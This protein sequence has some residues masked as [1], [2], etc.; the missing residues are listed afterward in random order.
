[1]RA[2]VMH[3]F[4]LLIAL[5]FGIPVYA[6]T[7]DVTA[8]YNPATYEVGGAKFINTTPCT[9][10]PTAAGFWCS[11]TATVDMPQAVRFGMAISRTVKKSGDNR[12]GLHYIGFPGERNVTLL[13]EGGG[14]SYNIK[15]IITAVGSEISVGN[16]TISTLPENGDCFSSS[17]WS[18]NVALFL[19]RDVKMPNQVVG[20]RCYGNSDTYIGKNV[21]IYSAYLGYKLKAP[22]PL[23]M[24]NGTYTGKL[25]LSI[26][27]KKDLDFG[28]GT[29]TDTELR[30]SFK[31]KVRHQIKVEFTPGSDKV[32]LQPPGGWH[33]WIYRGKSYL[34]PYLIAELPYR[35]WSSS[36]YNVWLNC[37]YS[38]GDS[39]MLNN[40]RLKMQVLLDVIYVNKAKKEI[41]LKHGI[42]QSFTTIIDGPYMNEARS[43]IFKI[44]KPVLALM[45]EYPGSTYKGNVTIIYD[46]A[47]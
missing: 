43:I 42:T 33:D 14:A 38:N 27:N 36:D 31:I 41:A 20:G 16:P 45:M 35:L 13:K 17:V 18:N 26:G 32:V 10:F 23:K 34:P 6:A 3:G 2:G 9:Q 21:N 4:W 39:C 8:E 11:T 37:Q 40:E 15:F 47:I 7:L 46:A 30:V 44:R 29:Y 25:T 24:E 1:M 28:D 12:E 22:D 19:Y 5:S